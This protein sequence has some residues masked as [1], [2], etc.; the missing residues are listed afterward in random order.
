MLT[1]PLEHIHARSGLSFGYDNFPFNVNGIDGLFVVVTNGLNCFIDLAFF[2]KE[3]LHGVL[4][5]PS[6][7]SSFFRLNENR[8]LAPPLRSLHHPSFIYVRTSVD[9]LHGLSRSC[10]ENFAAWTPLA[11][12]SMG[13]HCDCVNT[14]YDGAL[15]ATPPAIRPDK[16]LARKMPMCSK[17]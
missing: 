4:L 9:L 12:F 8:S 10:V 1:K 3:D 17:T 11:G 5:K 14:L 15:H 16:T 13:R 2:F 7:F 6:I